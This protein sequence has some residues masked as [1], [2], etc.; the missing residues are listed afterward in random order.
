MR[1]STIIVKK[2]KC[3]SCGK[4]C[5]WFS[6]KRCADCSR[7]EDFGKRLEK[8]N[9]KIIQEEDLSGLIEDADIVIS[10]YIRLKSAD[11]NGMVKCFTCGDIKHWTVTDAGHYIS[12]SHL[13]LRW[14]ERNLKPQC[15][16]CNRL[17]YGELA[18]YSERLN[19]ICQGLPDIL[20]S[21]A[22]IVHKPSRDEIRQ[23]IAE[24][25]PKVK[26]LKNKLTQP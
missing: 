16:P 22:T 21:E 7:I 14:D 4:D 11:K 10:Q 5:F 6:K 19:E 9:E 23:I 25:T 2:K 18:K 3:V 15:Q 17:N 1:N 26:T 13:Y 24:Y 20:R 8:E 12:R